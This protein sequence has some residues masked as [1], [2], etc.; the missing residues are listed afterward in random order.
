MTR[1]QPIDPPQIRTEIT[2][3]YRA[4][5]TAAGWNQTVAGILDHRSVRSYLPDPL[6]EGVLETLVAAASSAPS[7]SNTQ[8]WNV[9]AVEDPRTRARIAGLVGNQA[10]VAQAPLVLVWVAGLDR[11]IDIAAARDVTLEAAGYID[12][13]LVATIDAVIAAQNVVVAAE[14]LGLGTVY[15]GAI[16]NNAE[17]VAR[18]LDLPPHSY[19]VVGLVVGT[20]DPMVETAVKP[21]LPQAGVLHRERYNPDQTAAIAHLDAATEAFRAEQGLPPQS[22]SDLVVNRLRTVKAL[23]GRERLR[24]FFARL[25]LAQK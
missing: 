10:H 7:S 19:A 5:V 9:V 15:I 3:R 12:N 22:W 11:A 21:R 23:N 16:R 25:G 8:T 2:A 18:L 20:P 13:F 6:P 14:S 24:E 1:H 4:P 17:E